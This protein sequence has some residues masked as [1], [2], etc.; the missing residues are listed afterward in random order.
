MS[1]NIDIRDKRGMWPTWER[2]EM[3]IQFRRKYTKE[4]ENLQY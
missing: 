2:R 1:K 4:E 3:H